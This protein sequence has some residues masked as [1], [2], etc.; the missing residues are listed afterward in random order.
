L[1]YL[2]HEENEDD[3]NLWIMKQLK[4]IILLTVLLGMVG[5]KAFA[6]DFEV[7]GIYYNYSS[8][9]GNSVYVTY[10][11]RNEVTYTGDIVVPSSVSHMGNTYKVVAIGEYAFLQQ[12][13]NGYY[14]SITSISLPNT[15]KTIGVYAFSSNKELGSISIPASVTEIKD[16]A[17]DSCEG[18]T[19]V[20][21][22]KGLNKIAGCAFMNCSSLSNINIPNGVT[23]I[24]HNAFTFCDIKE[25]FLP[26]TVTELGIN[27]FG[28][29]N[30][31]S[32]IVDDENTVYDSR[33]NCNA[34]IE[35]AT[36]K[37]ISGCIN[38]DIPSSVQTIGGNSF[39]NIER[40][41]LIIP[42]GVANIE[43]YAFLQSHILS[44]SIPS[45]VTSISLSYGNWGGAKI[46]KA[47]MPI[48]PPTPL[49]ETKCPYRLT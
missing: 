1:G 14:R 28:C 26:K 2:A 18:L 45:S 43:K 9:D 5:A 16:W 32:I 7:D 3:I 20:V 42:E 47:N 17:F 35:T 48:L 46:V 11:S 41:S 25:L 33:H 36:N 10:K 8:D 39:R 21:L 34:I 38:T 49:L 29:R 31:A 30:L 6:Y 4:M 12:N 37:L 23:T 40:P 15:I 13:V 24:G 27:P 19:T 22:Q 44:I